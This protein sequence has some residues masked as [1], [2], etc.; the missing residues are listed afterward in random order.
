MIPYG[1]NGW[2]VPQGAIEKQLNGWGVGDAIPPVKPV[3]TTAPVLAGT[4]ALGDTLTV[5]PGTW[6]GT[7]APVVTRV[8]KADGTAIAGASGL[9]YQ[10]TAAE[11][12]KSVTVTETATNTGGSTSADSNAIAVPAASP[13]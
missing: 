3:S 5:T 4:T 6:T 1:M 2:G 9:T 8:W 7:P 11:Q 10:I 12:G 13:P